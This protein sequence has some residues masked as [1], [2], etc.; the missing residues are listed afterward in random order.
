M[1]CSR[2]IK[3]WELV[4][5]ELGFRFRGPEVLSPQMAY[6]VFRSSLVWP[7]EPELSV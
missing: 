2:R 1:A 4:G 6:E 7:D 5:S 3:A